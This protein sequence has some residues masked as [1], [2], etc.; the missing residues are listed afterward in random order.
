MFKKLG[1]L[2]LLLLFVASSTAFGQLKIG[3]MNTQEVLSQMPERSS[4]QQQ[5][6]SFIKQ[7]REEL[8]QRTTAF[9]DSVADYQQNRA[10]MSQS[11]IQQKEQ[12][13]T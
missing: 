8:Q 6:N 5:L 3:Y 2:L 10:N 13:L 1:S 12:R 9:Q 7:K 11:Q 4:V